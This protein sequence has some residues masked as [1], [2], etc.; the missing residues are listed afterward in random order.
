MKS[1]NNYANTHQSL[2]LSTKFVIDMNEFVKKYNKLQ[3]ILLQSK[4]SKKIYILKKT[5][6]K[7]KYNFLQKKKKKDKDRAEIDEK[8]LQKLRNAYLFLQRLL[9]QGKK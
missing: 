2:V 8:N 4:K 9:E 3:Q 6:K 1:E 5:G 7:K